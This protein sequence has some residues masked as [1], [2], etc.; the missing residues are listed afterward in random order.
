MLARNLNEEERKKQGI[1]NLRNSLAMHKL[2]IHH[3]DRELRVR[4]T[5][6]YSS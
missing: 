2:T 1:T 4:N 5:R 6:K 3:L